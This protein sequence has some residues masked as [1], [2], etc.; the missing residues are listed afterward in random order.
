MS[1]VIVKWLLV[2]G[3]VSVSICVCISIWLVLYK[4]YED[5][6]DIKERIAKYRRE[7]DDAHEDIKK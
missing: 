2:A 4:A 1:G 5:R 7:Y 6:L 3:I